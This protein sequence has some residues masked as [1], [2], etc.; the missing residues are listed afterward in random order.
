MKGKEETPRLLLRMYERMYRYFGP[1]HWWPA[2]SPFEVIV[3]AVLT[4]NTAW[5]NVERAIR[6]LKERRLLSLDG[7]LSTPLDRLAELIRPSG[8][9]N[10]KAKRL[11]AVV[12]FIA[13]HYQGNL[14]RMREESLEKLRE[15]WLTVYGVGPETADSI[16]LYALNKPIF[17]VDAYT[18]R[19]FSRH[20][21]VDLNDS[22]EDVQAFFMR[23]LP[24]EVQLFN[25]YHALVVETG[26]TFCRKKPKCE[27]CPLNGIGKSGKT[28]T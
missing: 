7:I 10:L 28:L 4:Q 13:E 24:C 22:Y 16:L 17:V 25:E 21:L 8:Y 26:K 6:N 20:G 27:D 2:E 1:R 12:R 11:K 18:K 15:K 5:G 3:G 14:D 23:H 9:Y 19:I